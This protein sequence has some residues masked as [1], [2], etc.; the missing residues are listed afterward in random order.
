M[1]RRMEMPTATPMVIGTKGLGLG[2]SSSPLDGALGSVVVKVAVGLISVVDSSVVMAMLDEGVDDV[3]GRPA[4]SYAEGDSGNSK[5]AF[6]LSQR[7]T[8]FL[9]GLV[10]QYHCKSVGSLY[11]QEWKTTSSRLLELCSRHHSEQ[12]GSCSNHPLTQVP[13]YRLKG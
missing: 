2:L 10:S 13:R 11:Q 5:I 4:M 8:V 6:R 12:P 9:G 3:G 7:S 1:A